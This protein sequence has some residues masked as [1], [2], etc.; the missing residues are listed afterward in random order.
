MQEDVTNTVTSINLGEQMEEL[1]D[2]I[3]TIGFDMYSNGEAIKMSEG[4]NEAN[5][6]T[7]QTH[8]PKDTPFTA[9]KEHSMPK[10]SM[11]NGHHPSRNAE[12]EGECEVLAIASMPTKHHLSD[13]PVDKNYPILNKQVKEHSS[14]HAVKTNAHNRSPSRG[15]LK[16]IVDHEVDKETRLKMMRQMTKS[17]PDFVA[18][19]QRARTTSEHAEENDKVS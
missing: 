16:T 13:K 2:P 3:D 12:T 9:T 7:E 4:R 10:H 1:I 5:E 11:V 17:T 15:G 6:R 19:F 14:L 18:F 8:C